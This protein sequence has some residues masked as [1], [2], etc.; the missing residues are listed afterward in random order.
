MRKLIY[1]TAIC[2][3]IGLGGNAYADADHAEPEAPMPAGQYQALLECGTELE[4]DNDDVRVTESMAKRAEKCLERKGF[5]ATDLFEDESVEAAA[6]A[7]EHDEDEQQII[8]MGKTRTA[9]DGPVAVPDKQQLM[10]NLQGIKPASDAVKDTQ[11]SLEEEADAVE[12]S[13]PRVF[14]PSRRN[15]DEKDDGPKPV[16]LGR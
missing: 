13:R 8:Q 12:S 4:G 9:A 11:E 6:A 1:T 5:R 3:L 15:K 14:V 16:F 10:D 7:H 2:M